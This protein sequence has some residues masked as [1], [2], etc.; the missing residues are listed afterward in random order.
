[1]LGKRRSERLKRMARLYAALQVAKM[2]G[3]DYCQFTQFCGDARQSKNILA[4]QEL[5]QRGFIDV[6]RY[7]TTG[8]AAGYG[9]TEAGDEWLK[10][11]LQLQRELS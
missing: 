5:I 7:A 11:Y 1:M 6:K 8:Y 2:A 3:T 10:G 4:L 9:T